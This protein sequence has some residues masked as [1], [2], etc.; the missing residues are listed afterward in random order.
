MV[1]ESE[2]N[3][4]AQQHVQEREREFQET[5]DRQDKTL[6]E[7]RTQ[8]VWRLFN[9]AVGQEMIVTYRQL[10]FLSSLESDSE[11]VFDL[12]S[13]QQLTHDTGRYSRSVGVWSGY[14]PS[15]FV[16]PRKLFSFRLNLY[17]LFSKI[18]DSS[19]LL[20]RRIRMVRGISEPTSY[21]HLLYTKERDLVLAGDDV[22]YIGQLPKDNYEKEVLKESVLRAFNNP[23]HD[24]YLYS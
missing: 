15:S 7:F 2:L 20:P 18:N 23:A 14:I 13:G 9:Q 22:E 21:V 19:I 11:E 5:K 1:Q 10:N 16:M 12:A 3:R 24:Q 6:G 8:G 17:M 4:Y